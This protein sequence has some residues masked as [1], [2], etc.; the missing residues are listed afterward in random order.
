ML[1]IQEQLLI[2]QLKQHQDYLNV[3]VIYSE[4]LVE[5]KKFKLQKPDFVLYTHA[6]IFSKQSEYAD[7]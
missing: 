1:D 7:L 3:T 4:T 5:V 6:Q 2:K